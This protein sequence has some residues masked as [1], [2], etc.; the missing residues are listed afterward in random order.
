VNLHNNP[1]CG[2]DTCREYKYIQSRMK[3]KG[4]KMYYDNVLKEAHTALR[5]PSFKNGDGIQKILASILN[6][7]LP[8]SGNYTLSQI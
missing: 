2:F 4:M 1:Y 3:M 7:R 8:G 6:I 5:F